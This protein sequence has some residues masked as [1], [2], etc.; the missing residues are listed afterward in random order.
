[1]NLPESH[2]VPVNYLSA[3]FKNTSTSYK[4]YWFLAILECVRE[5]NEVVIPIRHL[6]SKMI[7]NVWYPVNYFSLSFGKQDRLGRIALQVKRKSLLKDN[8]TNAAIHDEL[9]KMLRDPGNRELMRN[10]NSLLNYVPYR[11]LSPWYNQIL[12]GLQDAKRNSKIVQLAS[13]GF[14]SHMNWPLYRFVFGNEESIELH[15]LWFEYLRR[16]NRILTDFC[17]WNLLN[18]LQKNN[19]NVPNIADK[20]FAP[21]SRDMSR[22]RKF[23]SLFFKTHSNITCI[24]SNIPLTGEEFSI[25]HFL[26]WKFVTHDL[27]WNLVPVPKFINSSKSDSLP[28]LL[29]YF[30]GFAKLQYD[31]F[32]TVYQAKRFKWLE[33]Y[34]NLYQCELDSIFIMSFE[35]FKKRLRSTIVPL[36]Q[37]AQNMGY[38]SNWVFK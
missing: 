5:E 16:H 21:E 20:L 8:A 32:R 34:S 27:L 4:F 25:D 29:K 23:W 37:I 7:S 2:G 33:D 17:L 24:Y 10:L 38:E 9:D 35:R 31:A 12:R 1:M 30:E 26:P 11:F 28:S 14:E 13:A 19:P 18:Y 22:A 3:V 15:R 36:V 6:L